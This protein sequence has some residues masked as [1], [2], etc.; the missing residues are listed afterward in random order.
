MDRSRGGILKRAGAMTVLAIACM[1]SPTSAISAVQQDGA[2]V[3]EYTTVF[4]NPGPAGENDPTIERYIIEQIDATPAG[5]KIAFAARDWTRQAVAA[6]VRNAFDRGV[7]VIGVIDGSE[8]DRP[9]LKAMV[10]ALGGRVIFCGTPSF[11]FNSCISNVSRPG[12]MHNKFWTFSELSDGSKNVVIQTSQ[13][14]TTPQ[15]RQFQDLVRID[16]DVALY[17]GYR[18]Y[19]EDMK[20]QNRSD[21]YYLVTSGDDDRNTMYPFPRR[22]PDV[23]TDDTIV[24]RLNEVDCSEGG[25][26]SGEGLIRV[27]QAFFRRERMAIA[28]KLI[29]LRNEGCFVQVINSNGDADVVAELLNA[30]I[31]VSPLFHGAI[32][33]ETHT[34]YWFVDAKS[35][36]TEVRTRIVYAGS[37][38]WRADQHQTDDMLLRVVD[39]GVYAAYESHWLGMRD[40]SGY[41]RAATV[42]VLPDVEAPYTASTV[43]PAANANGWNDTDVSVRLTGSDGVGSFQGNAATGMKRLHVEMSG[44]QNE[45]WDFGGAPLAVAITRTLAVS[46]EGETTVSFFSED[47]KGNRS[48][49]ESYVIRIDKTPPELTGLPRECELWPPNHRMVHVASVAATDAV[50]GLADFEVEAW[51]NEPDSGLDAEDVPGDVSVSGGEVELRAERDGDGPGRVYT[52]SATAG[53]LAGHTAAES[54]S[55]KVPHDRRILSVAADGSRA[56]GLLMR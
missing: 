11:E 36:V 55:C 44:A 28:Q 3:I 18:R 54:R 22:Q 47:H 7:D 4:A 12:L 6:A 29:A 16:G 40:R 53:D 32:G 25:A 35:T 2:A 23:W 31:E 39:D 5:A 50:S 41:T 17:D 38:N 42:D 1:L 19:V 26:P 24:D 46:A 9:F 51:S 49:T 15:L 14:F 10:D 8:R 52:V 48:P 30:G 43:T 45:I 20:A 56:M 21:H 13:N 37:A 27:A 34:K 33:A